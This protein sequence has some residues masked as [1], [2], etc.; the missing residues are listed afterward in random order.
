M[1]RGG[2]GDDVVDVEA[3]ADLLADGVVVVAGTSDST[4]APEASFRVYRNSAPRKA[5]FSTSA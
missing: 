3:D 5:F 4:R 2:E 1:A